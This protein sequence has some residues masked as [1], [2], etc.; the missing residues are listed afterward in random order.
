M[1]LTDLSMFLLSMA[2]LMAYHAYL[3]RRLCRNPDYSIQAHNRM[4]R[5]VWAQYVMQNESR[6]ILAIQTLR[7]STMAATFL[8]STAV[9]MM[10]GALNLTAQADKL[11]ASWHALNISGS[12]YPALWTAKVLLLV[13]D[14]FATFFAFAMSVRFYNHAGYQITLP[15]TIAERPFPEMEVIYFLNRAGTFYTLGMRGYFFAV[16]L[17]LWLF[18]PLLLLFGALGVVITLYHLDRAPIKNSP[19]PI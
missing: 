12:T 1:F 8:A 15:G 16:P 7:N 2:I 11:S 17:I 13:V 9:L 14:L 5:T 3:K 19:N 10:I 4:A 18:G 6:G